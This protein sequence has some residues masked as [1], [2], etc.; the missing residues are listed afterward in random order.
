M[1][2]VRVNTIKTDTLQGSSGTTVSLASGHTP[3]GFVPAGGI[4]QTLH[5]ESTSLVSS[6]STSYADTGFNL[7]ITPS[8]TSSKILIYF[9]FGNYFF[10]SSAST[11]LGAAYKF[12][13]DST[14][15]K[16][17]EDSN[18][19]T[20]KDE[21]SANTYWNVFRV[22]LTHL[23]S[24]STTSAVNY[25]LQYARK[26]GGTLTIKGVTKIILQEIAG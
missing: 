21:R 4:L 14:D 11:E 15:I 1:G 17:F 2:D 12:V 13:R 10:G 5:S 9:E 16:A 24:P 26:I 8:S 7:S 25:K 22:G 18:G 20:I 3:A 6:T 19:Y 23:D